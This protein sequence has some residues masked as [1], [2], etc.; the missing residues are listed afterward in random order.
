MYAASTQDAFFVQGFNAARDRLWQIDT[1]RRR[2]LGLLSEVFGRDYVQWDR[3][4]RLFL[5]RGDMHAE[6]LA[7]SAETKR[8]ASAFTAGINAYVRRTRAD[9]S[10]L[11]L[12]FRELGYAPA[13]WAP[14]D[15]ARIR[16]HGLFQ[17]V[18][19]EVARALVLRDF[20]P[21]AEELRRRRE[22]AADLT[23]PDGLDL[24]LIPD[25]V[26]QVYLLATAPVPFGVP[27]AAAA[28]G[29]DQ[30]P[31][32][33]GDPSAAGAGSNNWVLAGARTATGRPL[34]ANDPHRTVSVP[35]LRYMA[36]L[37]APGFDVI[38]AGE[39]ALPGISIGHNGQIAFGFTVFSVDQ[40]DLYVYRTC[41]DAPSDYRYQDRWEP[42]RVIRE[43]I[44]VRDEPA[45]EVE[46]AFTRHGPVIRADAGRHTAFAVRAA[47]LEPGMAPYLGSIDYM[48]ATSW[49]QFSAAMNRW[50]APGENQVYADVDGNIAW[51]AAGLTPI[52]PN[53]DG[54]LPV[55]GDGRYEWAGFYDMD[56]LPEAVNPD[57]GWI[58][59]ANEMNLPADYPPE[60]KIG[61]D[62]PAPYRRQRINEV[63]RA[64]TG[65]TAADLVALQEDFLSIPARQIVTGLAGLTFADP[66]ASA[67]ARLLSDWD[68]V[69]AAESAAAAVFQVWYRR[70]LRPALLL[71]A[72]AQALPSGSVEPALDLLLPDADLTGDARIDLQL[73][74]RLGQDPGG[75]TAAP[76][77]AV[78]EPTLRAAMA[79]LTKLLGED[80]SQWAW[81]RLHRAHLVHP[82]AG[83]LHEA[84]RSQ[85]TVGPLPRGGSSDTVGATT[86]LPD[87]TQSA[88]A[89]FRLVIDVGAW[90]NSL[91]MNSPGQAGDPASPHFADLF[92]A[93][94]AGGAIPL[95]YS[96]EQV[97]AVTERRILLVPS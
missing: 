93:W 62:W 89:S 97:E 24:T 43:L 67:A 72:L 3:A 73:F 63:L 83:L 94:A 59:T 50:G 40:E 87:F 27:A 53:W 35:S 37:S 58:A 41:P 4:A 57:C 74:E 33:G 49:E 6:W 39:P 31:A 13:W 64:R 2:G 96:R 81:G 8:I 22:P 86:Y 28:A 80:V 11:P 18:A 48:R 68:C 29:A 21:G 51:K 26:L 44:P 32:A 23:I 10:L 30:A 38:G 25:D 82:A 84:S 12:E 1:W 85:V 20:G 70:H 78:V 90:D 7:Y 91:A 19:Q 15:V 52:R 71:H 75:G 76:L 88:G 61:Y 95:L 69:L 45:V 47:W 46:L 5:F 79:D 54:T 9:S 55:P 60:R 42:M 65:L 92:P 14:E 17:N 77:A 36:H 66:A 34:L 16:S 56:Q